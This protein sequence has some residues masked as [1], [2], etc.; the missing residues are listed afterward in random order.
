VG[1]LKELKVIE[2]PSWSPTRV[3]TAD[4]MKRYWL[5]YVYHLN[6]AVNS[7]IAVGKLDH[8][9]IENFW[10]EDPDTGLLVPGYKSYESF[11]NSALRD[12]KF[13]YARTG[14]SGGQK[15]EWG[16][17]DG[18]GYSKFLLGKIAESMG[19]VYTRYVDEEPRL[20]AEVKMEGEIE[21][22]KIMAIADEFRKDLVI[23]DH[24]SG[25]RKIGEYYLKNNIQMTIC[26]MCLFED[27]QSGFGG[28]AQRAYPEYVGIRLD[29]F[30][31]I[32]RVQIHDISAKWVKNEMHEP[33]TKVYEE[34]RTEQDFNEVIQFIQ[35]RQ[36]ALRE[37]DFFSSKSNCDY[38]FFNGDCSNYDPNDY[39]QGEYERDFPLFA[40]AGVF[41][42]SSH[43][44]IV[45]K[46]KQ[47][48]LR[49]K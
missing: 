23:R 19:M 42:D 38:C 4:C 45:S 6:Y 5:Q 33:I 39:H 32:A 47:K 12:W 25:N 43:P 15:I 30:L 17:Y 41:M 7:A 44:K 34:K 36:K 13:S 35:S 9:M 8:R 24:K 26:S 22:I 27:L 10:K 11:V 21:G 46:R 16:K 31:D 49:F 20:E 14:T 1:K 18:N 48:S 28:I 3:L 37:R 29:E 2:N 40:N